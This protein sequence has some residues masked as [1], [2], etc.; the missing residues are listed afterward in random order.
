MRIAVC[1]ACN[2][3]YIPLC[4][5]L[6][7]SLRDAARFTPKS[8]DVTLNF[9]DIGCADTSLT[10]LAEQGVALHSFSRTEYP[11]LPRQDLLPRYADAQLCRP[12][13]PK[14]VQDYD[15]YVWIDCDIWVQGTDAIASAVQ[16]AMQFPEKMVICPELHYGYI[17]QRNLRYAILAQ[18]RWYLGLYKDAD[19]ADEL[20]FKPM[21]NSGF[22]AMTGENSLWQ[23]WAE[24]LAIVYGGDHAADP[25]VLHYAE[26]LGLNRLL[27]TQNKQLPL[28]PLYN[29]ACGGS[30]V[31]LNPYGKVVI[32]FPPC[33][34]IKC[35]HLLAFSRYGR[36]YM[37]K[38]L[39]YKKG[40]YLT[41][42]ERV[43][44]LALVK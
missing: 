8:M 26:Q 15:Y 38:G 18:Q 42:G 39:L 13:L 24:E 36:M 6:V 20:S 14:I 40:S 4:K 1:F 29:Y 35:P 22:F 2:E 11:L 41:A 34:P 23:S 10:W 43:A 27:H 9:I 30:A 19:L 31:F 12:F 5:G 17:G 33:A 7:L 3:A 37:D 21:Y 25:S 16:A 44:L 32:G 28:D